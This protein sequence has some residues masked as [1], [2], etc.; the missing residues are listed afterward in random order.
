MADPQQFQIGH[1]PA[2]DVKA[3]QAEVAEL[4][5]HTTHKVTSLDIE[6]ALGLRAELL[7]V[8]DRAIKEMIR[9]IEAG[10]RGDGKHFEQQFGLAF[11]AMLK[12]TVG[13]A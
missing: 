9:A 6:R 12:R 4:L 1:L 13:G 8:K 5:D 3:V 7:K 11:I 2:F 10:A